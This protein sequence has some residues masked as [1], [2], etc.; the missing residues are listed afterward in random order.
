MRPS[1]NPEIE[2]ETTNQQ[3]L[4]Q[5]SRKTETTKSL[6]SGRT[7]DENIYNIIFFKW[8]NYSICVHDLVVLDHSI[9]YI[10]GPDLNWD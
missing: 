7:D 10:Y 5:D 9:T 1:N 4:L 8:P 6:D 2:G 3:M